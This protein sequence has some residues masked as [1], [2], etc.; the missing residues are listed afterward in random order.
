MWRVSIQQPLFSAE[1]GKGTLTPQGGGN[2]ENPFDLF[3]H[4]I[5]QREQETDKKIVGT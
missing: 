3:H 1:L 5:S 2:G 4:S